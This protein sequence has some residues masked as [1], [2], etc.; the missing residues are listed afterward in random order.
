MLCGSVCEPI[1]SCFLMSAWKL[2][3]LGNGGSLGLVC[4]RAKPTPA[5]NLH[6][7]LEQPAGIPATPAPLSRAQGVGAAG[8]VH[9]LQIS[10]VPGA[11][12]LVP[13]EPSLG[14]YG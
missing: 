7:A 3:H 5:A 14:R 8:E 2:Q 11:M 4:S 1:P 12:E 9:T 13:W 10:V 6:W